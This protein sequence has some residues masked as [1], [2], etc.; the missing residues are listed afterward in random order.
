MT[1]KVEDSTTTKGKVP[2]LGTQLI[3]YVIFQSGIHNIVSTSNFNKS[4]WI[5]V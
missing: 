3:K 1:R 4:G 5:R 2:S